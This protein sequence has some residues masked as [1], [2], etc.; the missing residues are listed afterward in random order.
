MAGPVYS[1]GPFRLEVHER[2]L[3]REGTP[4]PLSGKAFDTLVL[5][6]E[7]AGA[8]Q[9]QQQLMDRLWPDADVEPN[10]LQVNVSLVRRALEGVPGIELQT[11]RGRGYRL[12][13]S[14]LSAGDRPPSGALELPN[15]ETYFCDATDGTR[16]AWARVGEG[17]PLMKVANWLSHLELDWKGRVWRE[18]IRLLARGRQL[19]RYDARGNGLSAWNPPRMDFESF[20]ADLG[21]VFD[22]A[23]VRRAPLLG[24]SQGAA[25]AIAFAARHPER[26]SRLVLVGGVARGWRKIDK[27]RTRE[28]FEAMMVLMRQGW[29]GTNPAFR[30]MFTSAFFP[31]GPQEVTDWWN[32]LQRQ[33][34]TPENAA[35]LLSAVGSF[36]VREELARIRVPTLVLH[37]REDAVIPMREGVTLAAGIPGARFVPLESPN[38]VLVPDE[39]AWQR[40]AAEIEA[41]LA[42]ETFR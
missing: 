35:E 38:H 20:L 25:I 37:S 6:V 17:P 33:T 24:L 29:G 40:F 7:G 22:A 11:V 9:P 12:M 39:P 27:P 14:V 5:L 3:L 13:A 32:E 41:F 26:V 15:Q 30:Q 21:T 28:R 10:N 1:F 36:D 4:V 18:W 34:T 2:R 23:G 16:L 8:L 42:Q 19:V 31:R